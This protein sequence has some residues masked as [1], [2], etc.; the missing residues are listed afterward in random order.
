[1]FS[2]AAV[3]AADAA[4]ETELRLKRPWAPFEIDADEFVCIC[5][6]FWPSNKCNYG[7][8]PWVNASVLDADLSRLAKPMK[9]LGGV[10]FRIGGTQ[11]DTVLFEDGKHLCK[12]FSP[13]DQPASLF[14]GGCLTQSRWNEIAQFCKENDCKIIYGLNALLGRGPLLMQSWDSSNARAMLE[15]IKKNNQVNQVFGFELGNELNLAI[16]HG[17]L[18]T[19]KELAASFRSLS[20]LLEEVFPQPSTPKLLGPDFTHFPPIFNVFVKLTRD[21]LDAFTWHAYPLGGSGNDVDSKIMD[22]S[23]QDAF[24][25]EARRLRTAVDELAGPD[26]KLWMGE[27]GGSYNSGRNGTGNAFIDAFWYL[28]A[29]GELAKNGHETFCRQSLLGGN[30][31]LVDKVTFEPNPDFY[32]A[33]FF[34]R[35]MSGKVYGV[36]FTNDVQDRIRGFAHANAT[37]FKLIIL[38]YGNDAINVKLPDD[39]GQQPHDEF[40]F[41]SEGLHAKKV[42]LNGQQLSLDSDFAM[43]KRESDR[44]ILTVQNRSYVFLQFARREGISVEIQ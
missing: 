38:N 27:T 20:K 41:T 3:V 36:N 23:R 17:R 11:G 1:V 35:L 39:L 24:A 32:A 2:V 7:I 44:D 12:G 8:C 14:K 4:Y 31:E 29:M 10:R 26:V 25:E 42:L 28:N 43:M 21:I 6:D 9:T 34:K 15:H 16:Q 5:M 19:M 40:H 30:Y 18:L 13:S 22:P 37:S 33:V